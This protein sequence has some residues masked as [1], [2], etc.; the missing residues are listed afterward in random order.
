MQTV[1]LPESSRL[2]A[3]LDAPAERTYRNALSALFA[4]PGAVY[5]EGLVAVTWMSGALDHAWVEVPRTGRIIDP[6]PRYCRGEAGVLAYFPGQRWTLA[7][8][9]RLL[10]HNNDQLLLPL[11]VNHVRFL[12]G[13]P[14]TVT[15]AVTDNWRRAIRACHEFRVEF[16]RAAG[17]PI[18]T[19]AQDEQ[20]LLESELSGWPVSTPSSRTN[21]DSAD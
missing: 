17:M 14:A 1:D 18:A 4:C 13:R 3:L 8:V 11:N 2:A 15:A 7:Q 21:E 20:Q 5:V 6:S 16:Y 19:S 12:R 9:N 10:A